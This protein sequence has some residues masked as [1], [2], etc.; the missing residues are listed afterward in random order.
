MRYLKLKQPT[1][2]PSANK[3]EPRILLPGEKVS[4]EFRKL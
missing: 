1:H 4:N 2:K 3:K